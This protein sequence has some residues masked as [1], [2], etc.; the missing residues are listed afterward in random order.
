MK[1]N[2]GLPEKGKK[3]VRIDH[4]TVIFVS[5]DIPDDVA[6]AK[7]KE[8]RKFYESASGRKGNFQKKNDGLQ[9][10]KEDD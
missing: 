1:Q 10:V 2:S 9:F 7:Y 3:Q 8:K 5:K 4:K 6:I